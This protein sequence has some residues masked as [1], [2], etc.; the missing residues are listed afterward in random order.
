M[1]EGLYIE[2]E[3]IDAAVEAAKKECN[4]SYPNR[5]YCLEWIEFD[6]QFGCHLFSVTVY[7][8]C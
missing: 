2:I 3:D 6:D 1:K 4:E 7:C 5:D 8:S